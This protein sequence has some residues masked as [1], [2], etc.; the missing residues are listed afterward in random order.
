MFLLLLFQYFLFLRQSF[1]MKIIISFDYKSIDSF[2]IYLSMILI[3]SFRFLIIFFWWWWWWKKVIVFLL[4]NLDLSRFFFAFWFSIIVIVI[5]FW[6]K[7]KYIS[8]DKMLTKS[9]CNKI[10]F[11]IFEYKTK[12]KTKL[13]SRLHF[14][15]N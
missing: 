2:I 1:I 13:K 7:K 10:E 9:R 14:G 8:N 5:R 4:W 3:L 15:G 11:Q 6:N 12:K